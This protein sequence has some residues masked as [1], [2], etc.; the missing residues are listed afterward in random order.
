[1]HC[2][3][4]GTLVDVGSRSCER[5]KCKHVHA[6]VMNNVNYARRVCTNERA[7]SVA[8]ISAWR[9]L[10]QECIKMPSETIRWLESFGA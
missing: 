8:V 1:M 9:A 6:Q 4:G 7:P 10:I 3:N 5:E 2:T